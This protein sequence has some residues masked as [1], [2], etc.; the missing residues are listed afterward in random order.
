M[1]RY[2]EGVSYRL[3]LILNYFGEQ[4]DPNSCCR[5]DNS[6][7]T[8]ARP[9][10]IPAEAIPPAPQEAHRSAMPLG[11]RASSNVRLLTA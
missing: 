8:L 9:A 5:C 11:A 3:E 10:D 1:R 7:R 2:A 6:L 4:Y